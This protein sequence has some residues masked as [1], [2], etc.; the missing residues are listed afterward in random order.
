MSL[1]L[2]L[3]GMTLLLTAAGFAAAGFATYQLVESFLLDRLDTDLAEERFDAFKDFPRPPGGTGLPGGQGG[4]TQ[5]DPEYIPVGSGTWAEIRAADGTLVRTLTKDYGAERPRPDLP[6]Q[7]SVPEGKTEWWF[8]APG[9][10]GAT[11]Y[12]VYVGPAGKDNELILVAG[13]LSDI[14]ATLDRLL[15]IEAVVSLVA[16]AI[17][18]GIG[19]FSVRVGLRPLDGVVETA[20]AITA[21]DLSRRAP[22]GSRRTEVGK[23]GAAFNTMLGAIQESFSRRDATEQKLRRF[24]ADASHE[25]RTPLTSLKGYAEML[26]RP[27]LAQA[28]RELA[29]RRIE[30][31]SN[32]MARLVDDMLFLA[33]MDEEPPLRIQR[34]DLVELAEGAVSDARAI[35]PVRPISLIDGPPVEVEGDRDHLGRAIAN[36]LANVRAHTRPGTPVRVSVKCD[37]VDAVIEVADDGAGIPLESQEKLFERFYRVDKSRARASGGAGLGLSIVASIADAHGGSVS[38]ESVVGQGATFRITLPRADS[39]AGTESPG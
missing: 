10:D 35:E 36:L 13:S 27:S 19:Y 11:D 18:G 25:L 9:E 37:G 14:D 17:I 5:G 38:L 24:V 28:D 8:T 33:R 32:R 6:D 26:E 22:E 2:R 34:L 23:L 3:I 12:R 39:G 21:G 31:A 4:G 30:E 15:V 29:S 16:L 20:D 7:L 1:R